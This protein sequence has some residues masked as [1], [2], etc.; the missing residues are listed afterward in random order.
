MY[1]YKEKHLLSEERKRSLRA[2]ATPSER[3]FE[4]KLQEHNIPHK[5]QKSLYAGNFF[6]IVDFYFTRPYFQR[7]AIEIDGGYHD[8][9]EAQERDKRKNA[10]LA[11]RKVN[12]IRIKNDDVATTNVLALLA[13]YRIPFKPRRTRRN[14]T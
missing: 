13:P 8:L 14:T 7:L 1:T 12:L 6:C 11:K 9:P 5:F 2:R 4:Q 3:L 10:Y